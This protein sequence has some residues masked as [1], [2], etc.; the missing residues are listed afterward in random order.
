MDL[1][2]QEV[3]PLVGVGL[4]V[5]LTWAAGLVTDRRRHRRE[6]LARLQD[7]RLTAYMDFAVGAKRYTALLYQLGG[8]LQLD[9]STEPLT[10]EEAR[11]RLD[12]AFHDRDTAFEKVRLIGRPEVWN[13]ARAWVRATG[14]MRRALDD[15]AT[16]VDV[17][18]GLV[19][20]AQEGR[21]AFHKVARQDIAMGGRLD[22]STM[23]S[24]P[25]S[26][27]DREIELEA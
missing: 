17:W 8:G 1:S 12:A 10:W 22:T 25:L 7:E 13:A 15:P 4:G 21:D 3:L 24:R 2:A 9:A 20:T 5:V 6:R 18:D 27:R 11:P 19:D 14:D 16:T 26:A 23:T